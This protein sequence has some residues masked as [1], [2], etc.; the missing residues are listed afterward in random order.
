MFGNSHGTNQLLM[1]AHEW[2][3]EKFLFL[4]TGEVY[5]EVSP[6]KIP[7]SESD[8]GYIDILSVR[9]CYCESKRAAET[10]IVSYWK[11]YGVPSVIGR[12]RGWEPTVMPE[13][14][15]RRTIK[16]YTDV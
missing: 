11:Q 15:F 2:R 10:L 3:S 9:S 1:L 6:D 12:F 5:G 13:A 16:Y 4:S 14:G 8:Y 7:T